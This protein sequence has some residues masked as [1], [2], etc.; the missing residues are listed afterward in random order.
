MTTPELCYNELREHAPDVLTTVIMLVV[1]G[2][3]HVDR[4]IDLVPPTP[5]VLSD[6][7]R[8]TVERLIAGAARFII[9]HVDEI[10]AKES[11]EWGIQP[12]KANGT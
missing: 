9:D 11:E 12:T 8:D 2:E 10:I 6:E 7:D 1:A 3:R 5:D 4:V